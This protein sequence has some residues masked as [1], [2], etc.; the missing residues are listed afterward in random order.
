M[1]IFSDG[2]DIMDPSRVHD[3]VVVGGGVAGLC[4]AIAARRNGASTL[5]L[6]TAPRDQRGG[7]SRHGRNLR[8]M[9]EAPAE[10]LHG[11]Y[12][13]D[14]YWSDLAQV[15]GPAVDEN[16]ARMTIG[17]SADAIDWLTQCGVRFQAS[18]N[19]RISPSRKTAY[20]VGGG[21]AVLNACYHTAARLGVEIHYDAEVVSLPLDGGSVLEIAVST[22]GLQSVFRAKTVVVASG[23]HQANIDWLKRDWGEAAE[24]FQIRGSAFG[25]GRVLA[26]LLQQQAAPVGDPAQ[27][28][29]V[30]VDARGPKFDGGIVTRLDCAPFGVVVDRNGRRFRDEGAEIGPRRYAIWGALLARCPDQI[31]YAVF[32]ADAEQFFHPSIYPPIRAHTIAELAQKLALDPGALIATVEDY[33]G[34]VRPGPDR[35]PALAKT[36]GLA[37]P[38]TRWALPILFPPF[39]AYPMRPGVTFSYLGVKVDGGARVLMR[40]G[41]ASRNVFAAGAIMAANILGRGY[42]AGMGLTVATVFGRIAGRA[43]AI[44]AHN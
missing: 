4:A 2:A 44:H 21:K 41:R 15:C 23:G 3:V 24:N 39:G 28:H 29:M 34:A 32:D 38:K 8:V 43:A 12:G 42:L 18:G 30:A 16:L 27:C 13:Q 17:E 1:A 9:H 10:F 35:E 37:P 11:A 14:D 40:D 33:N 25:Q 31:A 36:E 19:G 20:L 6:E 22:Q 26:H 7:N 5:L